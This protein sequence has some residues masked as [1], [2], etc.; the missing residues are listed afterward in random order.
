MDDTGANNEKTIE[1]I[2]LIVL[3]AIK[4]DLKAAEVSLAIFSAALLSYRKDTCLRP[5]PN[6]FDDNSIDQDK[7]LDKLVKFHLPFF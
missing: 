3:E 7:K 2:K 6:I 4:N 1:E 5:C